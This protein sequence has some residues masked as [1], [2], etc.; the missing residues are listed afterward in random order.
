[1]NKIDLYTK[2]EIEILKSYYKDKIINKKFGSN[3][4]SL[5]IDRFEVNLIKT[6]Y[7]MDCIGRMPAKYFIINIDIAKLCE[8]YDL[9][10]PSEV[11]KNNLH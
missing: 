2:E 3:S 8:T 7:K 4:Y 1:M 5:I 6:K 9:I 11:I 10:L